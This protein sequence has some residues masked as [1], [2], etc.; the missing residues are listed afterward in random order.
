MSLN[1]LCFLSLVRKISQTSF[2]SNIKKTCSI[3]FQLMK[4][5][6]LEMDIELH[7]LEHLTLSL[8]RSLC[9]KVRESSIV[10]AAE[11][12]KVWTFLSATTGTKCSTPP[13]HLSTY[14]LTEIHRV[15]TKFTVPNY[16]SCQIFQTLYCE[17]VF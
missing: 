15:P 10:V 17:N 1:H 6:K 12:G 16:L 7:A 11:E 13:R 5:K 8:F 9:D 4:K 14:R 2:N 3:A